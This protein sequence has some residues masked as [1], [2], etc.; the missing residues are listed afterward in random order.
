MAAHTFLDRRTRW[1]RTT[2]MLSNMHALIS[3]IRILPAQSHDGSPRVQIGA[4]AL[5]RMQET[6]CRIR[7]CTSYL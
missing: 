5:I 6:T 1:T 3:N 4:E 2:H 7:K